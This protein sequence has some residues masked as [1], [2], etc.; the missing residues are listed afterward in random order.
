MLQDCSQGRDDR[1]DI[2]LGDL[3]QWCSNTRRFVLYY[4][5]TRKSCVTREARARINSRRERDL[6]PC[7]MTFEYVLHDHGRLRTCF[8][9]SRFGLLLMMQ[10]EFETG[11]IC[12]ATS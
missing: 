1:G 7:G 8:V 6:D 10:H 5:C 9:P 3:H 4:V 11:F 2:L 12:L